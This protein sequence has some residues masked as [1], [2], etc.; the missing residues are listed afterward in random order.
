MLSGRELVFGRC[1]NSSECR[2]FLFSYINNPNEIPD[3]RGIAANSLSEMMISDTKFVFGRKSVFFDDSP[4]C[5]NHF[6]WSIMRLNTSQWFFFPHAPEALPDCHQNH[7]STQA[8]AHTS[9][10][11]RVECVGFGDERLNNMTHTINWKITTAFMKD[12][13]VEIYK[14]QSSSSW[15]YVMQIVIRIWS[16]CKLKNAFL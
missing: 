4:S 9:Y 2:D 1:I 10:D 5:I 16:Q 3:R 6:L 15:Q 11:Y 13:A 12:R 14:I 7:N 8:P